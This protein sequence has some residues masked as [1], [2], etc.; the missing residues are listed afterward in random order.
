VKEPTVDNYGKGP[1]PHKRQRLERKKKKNQ[2][3]ARFSGESNLSRNLM[4]WHRKN[5]IKVPTEE[6]I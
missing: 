4:T 3:I 6:G 5:R 1:S 2:G